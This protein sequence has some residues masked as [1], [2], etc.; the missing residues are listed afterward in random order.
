MSVYGV[1]SIGISYT[2]GPGN[3]GSR[4]DFLLQGPEIAQAA[5]ELARVVLVLNLP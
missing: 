1:G 2:A 5:E 3:W 4:K